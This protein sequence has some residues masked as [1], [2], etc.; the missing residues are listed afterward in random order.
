MPRKSATA[1]SDDHRAVLNAEAE[2]RKGDAA[3]KAEMDSQARTDRELGAWLANEDA[4]RKGRKPKVEKEALDLSDAP[5]RSEPPT[6]IDMAS[7][8]PMPKPKKDDD[9]LK[10][11]ASD[12]KKKSGDSGKNREKAAVASGP[13]PAQKPKGKAVSRG[14]GGQDARKR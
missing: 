6:A 2:V 8:A 7:D 10:K 3:D 5:E 4:P 13:G 11:A 14:R 9:K 1:L 12:Y